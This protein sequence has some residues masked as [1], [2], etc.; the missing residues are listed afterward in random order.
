[1]A[2]RRGRRSETCAWCL[3]HVNDD[4]MLVDM[5]QFNMEGNDP[6]GGII[7]C[8]ACEEETAGPITRLIE[9]VSN[10]EVQDGWEE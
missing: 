3:K 10:V 8:D 7:M 9:L 2:I 4:T 6:V 1:M 5:S